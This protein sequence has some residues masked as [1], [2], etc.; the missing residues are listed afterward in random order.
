MTVKPTYEELVFRVKQLEQEVEK[1]E[2]FRKGLKHQKEMLQSLL[3]AQTETAMLTDL[4]GTILAVNEI[5]E[6]RLGKSSAELI[7]LGIYD[8]LPFDTAKSRKARADEVV[9]TET[10]VRFQDKRNGRLYD[11][12]IYPVFDGEGKINAL[13]I[14][15]KDITKTKRAEDALRES[16]KRLTIA[17]ELAYDLIYEWTVEDD[18]L[19]WFGNLDD[20]LGYNFNEIPRTIEG[21]IKL[22]HPEDI[23]R[24]KDAVELHR[25]STAPIYYEY[26][27]LHKDGS[28]RYW[29]DHG[30]PVL[31]DE[32]LPCKW[33]G[34]CKDITER[35]NVEI[36]LKLSE[37]RFHAIFDQTFQFIGLMTTKGILIEAN[38][39]ALDFYDISKSDVLDIPFWEAPWW[40]HSPELQDMLRDAVRRAALGEFVRFEASHPAPDGVLHYVDVS[41]KPVIDDSGNVHLLIPEGRDITARKEMEAEL[42]ASFKEK[43]LLLQEVHHR[44]RNNFEIIS[45]LLD[46]VGGSTNNRNTQ[47]ILRDASARIHSMALIHSQLYQRRSFDRVD[48]REFAQ[49]LMNHLL[50][51]YNDNGK[52]IEIV[53]GPSN[54]YLSLNQAIPSAL[55]LN[56]LVSNAFKHA[57]NGKKNGTI[58]ISIHSETEDNITLKVKD[59]GNGI[60]KGIDF[61]KTRGLGLKLTKHLVEGQLKGEVLISYRSGTEIRV[62]FK[63]EKTALT[64]T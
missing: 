29:S 55:V 36:A 15:A 45:S 26:K 57:F 37:Q 56:E 49:I 64:D 16:E 50:S 25:T 1:R 31:N 41:I 33:I 28:Y 14:Y 44:V 59:D 7:G 39:A 19:E 4:E 11:N 62:G 38:Q 9:R 48:M 27:I 40:T 23:A 43:E 42:R 30:R 32:G 46:L 63:K 60:P 53:I 52:K 24:L 58:Q 51:I 35:K 8:Y 12:N 54:V 18:K 2:D 13:A 20:K 10:S 34:V 5:A 3:N 61:N 6:Q 17:G 21:W 22:I 47:N